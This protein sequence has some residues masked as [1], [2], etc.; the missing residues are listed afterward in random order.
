M[1]SCSWFL[2]K[3]ERIRAREGA[4]SEEGVTGGA[5]GVGGGWKVS[6]GARVV[7]M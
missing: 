2:L 3:G 5:Y 6:E 4:T 7:C 1:N